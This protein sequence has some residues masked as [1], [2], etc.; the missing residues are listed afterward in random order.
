MPHG[1][2]LLIKCIRIKK[3]KNREYIQK[4]KIYTDIQKETVFRTVRLTVVY[5]VSYSF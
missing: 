3:E 2:E 5:W 1:I 4:F